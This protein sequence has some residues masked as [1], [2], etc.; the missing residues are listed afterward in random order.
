MQ[1]FTWEGKLIWEFT[2]SSDSYMLHHDI[3]R[4]PNGNILMIAW[5]RKI[6]K[7][8]M[9]AGRNPKKLGEEGLWSEKVIEVN[10]GIDWVVPTLEYNGRWREGKI[11]NP[12]ELLKDL[13][14]MKVIE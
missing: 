1:E 13:K 5:E 10:G 4:L 3:E 2:Y 9:A 7:E 8:A 12:C 6:R 14:Q 11:F